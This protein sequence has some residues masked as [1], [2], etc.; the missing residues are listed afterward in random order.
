MI[1]IRVE[2]QSTKKWVM[3]L[4]SVF[5][6]FLRSRVIRLA[7]KDWKQNLCISPNRWI[8]IRRLLNIQITHFDRQASILLRSYRIDLQVDTLMSKSVLP[9]FYHHNPTRNNAQNYTLKIQVYEC[10][11][12][13]SPFVSTAAILYIHG[14]GF[15]CG[16][17][18]AYHVLCSY[19][20]ARSGG[21]PVFALDYPLSPEYQYPAQLEA[22]IAAYKNLLDRGFTKIGLVG[23]S[24]GGN[25]VFSVTLQLKEWRLPKPS[26]VCVMSPWLD[27]KN[28]G[29]S[30]RERKSLDP[31]LPVEM[32]DP[33]AAIYVKNQDLL[34]D[35]LVSP[36][37]ASKKQLEDF[38]P[39]LIHVGEC[40]ILMDDSIR[41]AEKVAQANTSKTQIG[42]ELVIWSG[43]IHAFQLA[44]GIFKESDQS[45]SEVGAF[46]KS[47]L[48]SGR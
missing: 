12:N 39:L 33:V 9:I 26:A 18:K 38:P 5:L 37:Y 17:S 34:I 41:F 30:L 36:I 4:V 46:M 32:M 6:R 43:M 7:Y 23:D 22:G 8:Q 27:L 29:K 19:I 42:V 10:G 15:F 1:Q 14:G 35:P 48:N 16:L 20:S 47:Y 3:K 44:V 13:I 25:L 28:T 31:V 21:I 11:N 45:L 24:A 40:E 2:S